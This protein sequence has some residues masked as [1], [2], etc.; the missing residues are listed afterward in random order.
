MQEAK[1]DKSL[2][3]DEVVRNVPPAVPG[4]VPSSDQAKAGDSSD[5]EDDSDNET[6]NPRR[7]GPPRPR[8]NAS[9]AHRQKR[10]RRR[11]QPQ[12][13][14]CPVA[15]R[16]LRQSSLD[17]DDASVAGARR[18]RGG[19]PNFRGN[20]NIN[21]G[22]KRHKKGPEQEDGAP[23]EQERTAPT[24]T[25]CEKLKKPPTGKK[26]GWRNRNNRWMIM[27]RNAREDTPP[28][29]EVD[30]EDSEAGDSAIDMESVNGDAH[31]SGGEEQGLPSRSP[32]PPNLPS[33]ARTEFWRRDGSDARSPSEEDE[34]DSQQQRRQAWSETSGLFMTA[35]PSTP[36]R[37]CSVNSDVQRNIVEPS[38][39]AGAR[40]ATPEEPD[41]EFEE[42]MRRFR[43][44]RQKAHTILGRPAGQP[45][46]AFQAQI[47]DMSRDHPQ[48]EM[49]QAEEESG[50]NGAAVARIVGGSA[51]QRHE[52]DQDA[53]V[54]SDGVAA[55]G[56]NEQ[57]HV[58][59][60]LQTEQG[61]AYKAPSQPAHLDAEATQPPLSQTDLT[62][63]GI[64]PE[65]DGTHSPHLGSKRPGQSQVQSS[66]S[67]M[68]R[69]DD[70]LTAAEVKKKKEE[71][72][73][74][75]K[76]IL[77]EFTMIS[78]G[79]N[80]EPVSLLS[81]DEDEETREIAAVEKTARLRMRELRRKRNVRLML[82]R[83]V[84]AQVIE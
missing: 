32:T 57:Q 11:Q 23:E 52:D 73:E 51:D 28:F 54:P 3:N 46:G 68:A 72:E 70:Q 17:A 50:N 14:D 25:R 64:K 39:S 35:E 37:G 40:S 56:S 53:K 29:E 38:Q 2:D 82:A 84:Q 34:E 62:D 67:K 78:I 58:T 76:K 66:P 45:F 79:T 83:G 81:E 5:S 9:V 31:A 49:L 12:V 33:P 27:P 19:A 20:I 48:G 47:A 63:L 42:R 36:R 10:K 69:M 74:P 59:T 22:A 41:P 21:T 71:S 24:C 55:D 8:R 61:D 43:E 30:D 18:G 44:S 77:P 1:A 75:E 7:P 60:E 6:S 4:I 15:H 80:E 65:R 13:C 16:P 26:I